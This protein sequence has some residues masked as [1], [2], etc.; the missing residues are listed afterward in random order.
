MA[1]KGP[2]APAQPRTL[3]GRAVE[4]ATPG[5]LADGAAGYCPTCGHPIGAGLP[6]SH[7][8]DQGAHVGGSGSPTPAGF[9]LGRK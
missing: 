3:R 2:S 7:Y 9:S 1:T 4:Q 8:E 6:H 5:N